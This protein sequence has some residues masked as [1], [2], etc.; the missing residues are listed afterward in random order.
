MDPSFGYKTFNRNNLGT[1]CGKVK[2]RGSGAGTEACRIEF[3][4]PHR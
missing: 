2:V 4:Y 3:T 1:K